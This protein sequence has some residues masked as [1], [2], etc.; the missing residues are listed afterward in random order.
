MEK[1]QNYP[2]KFKGALGELVNAVDEKSEVEEKKFKFST[3]DTFGIAPS[4]SWNNSDVYKTKVGTFYT[5]I[6]YLITFYLIF[7]SFDKFIGMVAPNVNYSYYNDII[8]AERS[9]SLY[10]TTFPIITM[11]NYM[12]NDTPQ[13]AMLTAEDIECNFTITG[14]R[15]T[16]FLNIDFLFKEG[17]EE[18]AVGKYCANYVTES[19]V[20]GVATMTLKNGY[21]TTKA[22]EI[23]F[24]KNNALCFATDDIQLHGEPINECFDGECQYYSMLFK[25]K[26]SQETK[27]CSEKI[28]LDNLLVMIHYKN[29]V[30]S[31]SVYKEPFDLH[32]KLYKFYTMSEHRVDLSLLHAQVKMVSTERQFGIGPSYSKEYTKT[33]LQSETLMLRTDQQAYNLIIN[34][35]LHDKHTEIDREY[36]SF[37]DSLSFFGG[38]KDFTVIFL[39]WIYSY[40]LEARFQNDLIHKGCTITGKFGQRQ[41][42]VKYLEGVIDKKAI[43][44][45]E[46]ESCDKFQNCL[47]KC[48]SCK[49]SKVT[50]KEEAE[51]NNSEIFD[52]AFDNIL[53]R[54][55]DLKH[56]LQ[57]S[58]DVELIK[59]V[60]FEQRHLVLAPLVTIECEKRLLESQKASLD[61]E[62]FK[63]YV[64]QYNDNGENNNTKNRSDNKNISENNNLKNVFSDLKKDPDSDDEKSWD[65]VEDLQETNN[66]N[67]ELSKSKIELSHKKKKN[68]RSMNTKKD[69]DLEDLKFSSD[70]QETKVNKLIDH[71]VLEKSKRI[72]IENK[73]DAMK[74]KVA[75]LEKQLASQ[76][77]VFT[78]I[79]SNDKNM[80]HS[81]D[82]T[83]NTAN[84][85]SPINSIKPNQ[86]DKETSYNFTREYMSDVYQA[87]ERGQLEGNM[88]FKTIITNSVKQLKYK[89]KH[90]KSP[91]ESKADQQFM[92]YLPNSVLN[93]DK[94]LNPSSAKNNLAELFENLKQTNSNKNEDN[95]LKKSPKPKRNVAL[96]ES[97][98]GLSVDPD[99]ST[100]KL[101]VNPK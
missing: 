72:T 52:E 97:N 32:H 38:L 56:M 37:I 9:V 99:E 100:G 92:D 41:S 39:A 94:I 77:D 53:T 63:N 23:Y 40:Y 85:L 78:K 46:F 34:F 7:I 80:P 11:F 10:G 87:I 91:M 69:T 21:V 75:Q 42:S 81:D 64:K 84:L 60:I 59:K 12:K 58:Q 93:C 48:F 67:F 20:D 83:L 33:I 61:E 6:F 26:S 22:A 24:I 36:W 3:F 95:F 19:T 4:I 2:K 82:T 17:T 57:L 88:Y 45:P 98:G 13:T 54:Q 29:A 43:H 65:N 79:N 62:G 16:N 8:P 74:K 96:D 49:K 101:N 35:L 55:T 5:L 30:P 73:F 68:L 27:N 50:P 47:K 76:N 25:Q 51:E 18:I 66:D 70:A 28:S 89:P 44:E 90:L 31:P 14:L 86:F 1:E 15:K 71:L